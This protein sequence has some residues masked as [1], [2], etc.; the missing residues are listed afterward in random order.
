MSESIH[1]YGCGLVGFGRAR[2]D[3]DSHFGPCQMEMYRLIA[4]HS[5]QITLSISDASL[6]LLANRGIL[7]PPKTR[8]EMRSSTESTISWCQFPADLLPP[9]FAFPIPSLSRPAPFDEK[10]GQFL[11]QQHPRAEA[12]QS[13]EAHKAMLAA[14]LSAMWHFCAGFSKTGPTESSVPAPLLA[15]ELLFQRRYPESLSITTLAR[16]VGVSKGHL[17]KL[18]HR[19]WQ[20]TPAEKLWRIRLQAAT[21]LLR[22][23]GLS[24]RA[25]SQACGFANPFHFSRRFRQ[26]FGCDP[27]TWRQREWGLRPTPE[28]NWNEGR[29]VLDY[30]EAK[31][32]PPPAGGALRAG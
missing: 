25:V 21:R 3:K 28:A 10:L 13:T 23:S 19:Y 20:T 14:V 17:I 9:A 31:R 1:P 5:G 32:L 22:E 30:P 12:P 18:A 4:V 6:T 7:L 29:I 2:Y 15:A 26:E 8:L 16:E 27:R 24:I 11:L